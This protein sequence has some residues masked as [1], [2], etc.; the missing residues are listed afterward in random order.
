MHDILKLAKFLIM[1]VGFWLVGREMSID[2]QR[3][4]FSWNWRKQV[5]PEEREHKNL[6]ESCEDCH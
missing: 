5:S 3:N 6:E 2:Q 1:N 4:I